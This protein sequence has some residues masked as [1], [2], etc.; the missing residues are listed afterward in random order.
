LSGAFVTKYYRIVFEEYDIK[1]SDEKQDNIILEGALSAP[2][3]CL[4]F[5]IR[6]EEQMELISKA[7]DKILQLQASQV[8]FTDDHCPKCSNGILKK[9][10]FNTSWFYDVFSDHRVTLPRRRCNTCNHVVTNTVQGLLE[11]S[12]SGELIKIQSELG[13]K[14][15]YRDSEN[16]I[17]QFSSKKRRINNHEKIHT[18]SESVGESLSNLHEVEEDILISDLADELIS[19][20][21]L[22]ASPAI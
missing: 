20:W 15:S 12:L 22:I 16:L 4:D 18:T 5:G 2:S 9:H 8:A 10:G 6:H 14:Y 19:R 7:Q 21:R 13:A 11:Q 1:P 17:N 3:N